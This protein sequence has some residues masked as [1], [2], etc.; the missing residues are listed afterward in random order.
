MAQKVVIYSPTHTGWKART[1]RS[2]LIGRPEC[3]GQAHV[4]RSLCVQGVLLGGRCILGW[5]SAPNV[6]KFFVARRLHGNVLFA[7]YTVQSRSEILHLLAI[8]TAQRNP[9][10][11][12]GLQR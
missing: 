12:L 4:S 7:R 1:C 3:R 11:L 8:E 9:D 6:Q 10:R 5:V 2:S